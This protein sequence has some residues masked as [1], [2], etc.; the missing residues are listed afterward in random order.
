MPARLLCGMYGNMFITIN[1]G[2]KRNDCTTVLKEYSQTR[3]A[4]E[5]TLLARLIELHID[6]I[7][8]FTAAEDS[9][10]EISS[11]TRAEQS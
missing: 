11:L 10:V 5:P 8:V 3:H 1:I 6:T 9:C 4:S 7:G 2:R